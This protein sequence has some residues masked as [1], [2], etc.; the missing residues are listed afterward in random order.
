M[1]KLFLFFILSISLLFSA[2]IDRKIKVKKRE[3]KLKQIE[4]DKMDKKLS[5]LAR[6]IIKAKKE[7]AILDKK[8]KKSQK[9]V[10]KNQAK[11][12]ELNKKKRAIDKELNKLNSKIKAK[13]DKF[14][15]LIADKLS[16]SL[17][18]DEL[19]KPNTKS[20]MLQEVYKVYAKE[21]EEKIAK[22]EK[23]ITQLNQKKSY[24]VEKQ[25]SLKE[26]IDKYQKQ[27][28]EYKAQK[29]KKEKLI[30]ELARDKVIYKKRFESIRASRRALRRKLA[31]LKIL[32][33]NS[34]DE[35]KVEKKRVS[36]KKRRKKKKKKR[37]KEVT[38]YRGKKT[39]SP[40]SGSVL[41]KRFGTYID[42]IYKFKIFNKSIT[43]KAP[44]QGAKV[45][46]V[47][48]GKVVF[49]ENSGGMLGKVV[50]IAHDNNLHTIYAKLSRLAPGIHAGKRVKKGTV[51]GK[52]D[53]SLMFEVTKNNKHINPLK[54]IRL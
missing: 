48:N 29:K 23:E 51:I 47:L 12:D 21:N 17:V 22:I 32:K 8:L 7:S 9:E 54:L 35:E 41:I 24:F 1:R 45:K 37:V 3:L 15:S 39:I 43:L 14:A 19:K 10:E 50:I 28:D 46:S 13:R 31:R 36:S 33:E 6:K 40:L 18:L 38:T 4:Y 34:E 27:I 42:P 5:N 53:S 26:A 20:I 2:S 11:F 25:Q 44:Y 49:A 30:K 16:I 52:V